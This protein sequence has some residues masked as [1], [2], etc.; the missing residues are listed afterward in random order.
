LAAFA[1]LAAVMES[2]QG[3]KTISKKQHTGTAPL[4]LPWHSTAYVPKCGTALCLCTEPAALQY[5]R[6]L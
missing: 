6:D 1:S 2:G 5:A 4:I 3:V